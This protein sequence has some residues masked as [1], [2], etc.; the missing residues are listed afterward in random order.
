[1]KICKNFNFKILKLSYLIYDYMETNLHEAT[2]A[3]ILEDIHKKYII[4]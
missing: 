1:M 3:G 2:R 4:Y